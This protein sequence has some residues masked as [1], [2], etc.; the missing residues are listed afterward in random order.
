MTGKRQEEK[1]YTNM[2]IIDPKAGFD[3]LPVTG[4]RLLVTYSYTSSASLLYLF[5]Y[6]IGDSPVIFLNTVLNALVS[7]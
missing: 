1:R 6:S 2:G 7:E 5:L 3:R 4:S